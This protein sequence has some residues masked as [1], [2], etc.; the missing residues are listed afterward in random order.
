M[1]SKIFSN[2]KFSLFQSVWRLKIMQQFRYIKLCV[3]AN[4][5]YGKISLFQLLCYVFVLKWH[6]SL[7]L[8]GFVFSLIFSM[9]VS[10]CLE[11]Y[12]KLA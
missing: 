9:V 3:Q 5:P 2:G 7:Y 4:R 10:L 8:L 12:I 1:F 11:L 6:N